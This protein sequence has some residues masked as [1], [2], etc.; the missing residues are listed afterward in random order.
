MAQ[1]FS[2]QRSKSAHVTLGYFTL[3]K[4]LAALFQ[5]AA[6]IVI[7]I[8]AHRFWRQ[9]MNMSRGKVWAGGWE[10]YVIMVTMLLVCSEHTVRCRRGTD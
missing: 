9:Q 3:G 8:G 2:L 1:L 6:I 4:P 7:T 5:I 10:I